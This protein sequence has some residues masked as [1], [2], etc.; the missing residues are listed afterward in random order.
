MTIKH[1]F[2]ST[3]TDLPDPTIIH[4]S[5]WNDD[6]VVSGSLELNGGNIT[7]S[8]NTASFIVKDATSPLTALT[9]NGLN[10]DTT[11][12]S[13]FDFG[14]GNASALQIQSEDPGVF[15]PY[16]YAFHNTASPVANDFPGGLLVAGN[17]SAGS[18]NWCSMDVKILNATHATNASAVSWTVQSGGAHVTPLTLGP[19]VQVGAPT[20]GDKGLGSINIAADIY[21]NNAAYTNPDYALE[22][23]STDKIEKYK[24]SE[25]A[26]RYHGRVRL[27]NLESRLKKDLRLPG[28]TDEPMGLFDRTDILLEKLEEAYIYIIE[29][30]NRLRKLEQH[31]QTEANQSEP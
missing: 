7:T 28:L 14:T 3:K 4:P 26:D 5:N 20:G 17:D 6:H 11:F 2:I 18:T 21:K 24:D 12:G 25:G 31:P 19:G 16:F 1:K 9:L 15:G 8:G 30:H 29:L 22:H 13:Q 27:E 23:W 10:F